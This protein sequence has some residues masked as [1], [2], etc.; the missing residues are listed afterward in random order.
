MSTLFIEC[1]LERPAEATGLPQVYHMEVYDALHGKLVVNLTNDRPTFTID[2]L[3]PGAKFSMRAYVSNSKG[4][5]LAPHVTLTANTLG[6][7][8]KQMSQGN[9]RAVH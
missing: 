4:L 8:E 2:Q 1:V 7:P 6:P 9:R 5:S 3:P